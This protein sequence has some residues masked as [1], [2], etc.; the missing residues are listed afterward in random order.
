MLKFFMSFSDARG[1]SV[2][3]SPPR[4]FVL[5]STKKRI[6]SFLS[7]MYLALYCI[8]WLHLVR[9]NELHHI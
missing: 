4:F 7:L 1:L 9:T 3:T 8:Y 5:R 2:D 6:L